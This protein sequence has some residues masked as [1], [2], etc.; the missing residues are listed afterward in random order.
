MTVKDVVITFPVLHPAQWVIRNSP[1]RFKVIACGR[2]WGKTL[3]I[4][5]MGAEALADGKRVAYF[6][7]SYRQGREVWERFKSLMSPIVKHKDENERRIETIT[8]G[9][10]DMW[11]L[12]NEETAKNSRGRKYDMVL[13]DEAAH[14]PILLSV[15]NKV[16]RPMLSDTQ[17]S[18]LFASSPNGLNDFYTLF[19]RG[20]DPLA[21][22]WAAFHYPTSSNP[23]ILL[24]EIEAARQEISEQAFN[25]EYLA[26]FIADGAGVFRGLSHVLT[27]PLE[28]AP[29]PGMRYVTGIDW[30][31]Q[32]DFTVIVVMD[33]VSRQMVAMDRFYQIDWHFQRERLK[34]MIARWSPVYNL[35]EENSIGGP[36]IEALQRDG[37]PVTPFKTTSESKRPLIEN[38]SL[39]IEQQ[40]ISLPDNPVLVNE[41]QAYGMKRTATGNWQY[42]APSGGHDDTV[43]ALALAYEALLRNQS[44][45]VPSWMKDR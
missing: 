19:Q 3:L 8:G 40:R 39:A 18:A 35:V 16:I 4:T 23:H 43:M 29:V 7:L 44:T 42:G 24:S 36:N 22:E 13:I 26:L 11:S 38:L 9:I 41:L 33:V 34:A 31:K 1:A 2:R 27:A 17:G 20:Q 6:N 30:G 32:N 28:S 25:Q 10:L 12:D 37:V 21:K 14:I 45:G 5:D 15:W